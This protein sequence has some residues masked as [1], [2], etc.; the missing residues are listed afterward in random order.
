MKQFPIMGEVSLISAAF[1]EGHTLGVYSHK[2]KYLWI[3]F[4]SRIRNTHFLC[5]SFLFTISSV[6]MYDIED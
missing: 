3:K 2:K 5:N 6:P 4:I 1:L